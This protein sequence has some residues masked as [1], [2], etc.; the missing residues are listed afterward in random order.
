MLLQGITMPEQRYADYL[1]S[2]DFIQR[3]I[4]PGGCLPSVLAMGQSV[5]S[6]SDMRLLHLE[7]FSEHYARTLQL[8]RKKFFDQIDEVRL[9]GFSERFIRMWE[10][11]FCYCEAAFLERLT[12]VVQVVYAKPACRIDSINT[13]EGQR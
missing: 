13:Q 7:D 3:Y 9:L 5:A 6:Q 8:W 4:F 10:Y 1:K 2:V 11:Y 12:G